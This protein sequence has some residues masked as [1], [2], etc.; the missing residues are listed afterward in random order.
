MRLWETRRKNFVGTREHERENG[1]ECSLWEIVYL[2]IIRYWFAQNPGRSQTLRHN[3]RPDIIKCLQRQ[4]PLDKTR[5]KFT[6]RM[7]TFA[8]RK[9]TKFTR[10]ATITE[11][12][13]ICI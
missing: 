11:V 2:D 3:K 4:L 5:G 7:D 1:L 13:Y 6:G 9:A 10:V 8:C 12:R